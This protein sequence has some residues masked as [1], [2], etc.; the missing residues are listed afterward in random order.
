LQDELLAFKFFTV[1][2]MPKIAR[3]LAQGSLHFI[4]SSRKRVTSRRNSTAS[5]PRNKAP[6]SNSKS[7]FHTAENFPGL[8][9][10][11]AGRSTKT[12]RFDL[13]TAQFLLNFLQFQQRTFNEIGIFRLFFASYGCHRFHKTVVRDTLP[14][15]SPSPNQP[16]LNAGER[17]TIQVAQDENLRLPGRADLPLCPEFLGGAAAP[18]YRRREDFCHAPAWRPIY[19]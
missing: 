17:K 16:T 18:P 4:H 9:H 7:C 3:K 5:L 1:G 2:E 13:L 11:A 6:R 12:L 15:A 14:F 10:G 8:I 19:D